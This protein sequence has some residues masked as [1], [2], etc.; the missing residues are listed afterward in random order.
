MEEQNTISEEENS[1]F[2]FLTIYENDYKTVL[3]N[4]DCIGVWKTN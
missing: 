3:N 2:T 1:T 4:I